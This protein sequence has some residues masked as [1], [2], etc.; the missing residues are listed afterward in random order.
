MLAEVSATVLQ[1]PTA[2]L[3]QKECQSESLPAAVRKLARPEMSHPTAWIC[4]ANMP[5]DNSVWK[6]ESLKF[7]VKQSTVTGPPSQDVCG[8]ERSPKFAIL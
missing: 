3:V 4:K 2:M 7:M 6:A 8:R 5:V 1:M